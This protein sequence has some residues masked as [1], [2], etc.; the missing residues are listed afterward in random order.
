[1]KEMY[2]EKGFTDYLSKPIIP[3]KLD[4]MIDNYIPEDK[5]APVCDASPTPA[6]PP[7]APDNSPVNAQAAKE[8][9]VQD[10]IRLLKEHIP[11]VDICSAV[12]FCANSE[13][14]YAEML[15]E[16][17]DGNRYQHIADAYR[18]KDIK[19]YTIEVHTLKSTSRT[20][21]FNKISEYAEKL[22]YAAEKN[23]TDTID[24]LHGPMMTLYE[25]TLDILRSIV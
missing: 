18:D 21:G 16:F 17:T 7:A 4:R 22:Q 23:D 20:V 5:K 12:R 9:T 8:F 24:S 2:I 11:D 6:D 3:E 10:K 15:K 13:D 19:Q 1:M 25:E 14:I